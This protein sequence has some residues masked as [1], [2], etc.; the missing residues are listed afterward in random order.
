MSED[1][2]PVRVSS[3]PLP[4]LCCLRREIFPE[5]GLN[6]VRRVQ[7]VPKKKP[8]VFLPH[9]SK[10]WIDLGDIIEDTCVFFPRKETNA[11]LELI[12]RNGR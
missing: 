6:K 12:S 1:R 7:W 2:I 8:S 9:Q 10:L 5:L 3:Y 11:A 4:T